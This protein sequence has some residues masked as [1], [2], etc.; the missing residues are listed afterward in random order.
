MNKNKLEA[1]RWIEQA[2]KDLES[3][4]WNVKGKFYAQA[5]FLCQQSGEKI[6]KAFLYGQGERLVLGHSLLELIERC[7]SYDKNF[8]SLREPSRLLDRFYIPTRYPNG[9]PSGIPQNYYVGEDS[10]QALS[11][12]EKILAIFKPIIQ[13][14][15]E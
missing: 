14:I 1:L 4:R 5:C 13:N 7:I 3:A 8:E 12:V 6:L 10:Q 9:L 15:S 2:E 11:S